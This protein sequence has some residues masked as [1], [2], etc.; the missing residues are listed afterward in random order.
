M[1]NVVR[2]SAKHLLIFFERTTVGRASDGS[3]ERHPAMNTLNSSKQNWV[4]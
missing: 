1:Y 3:G 4:L 2:N